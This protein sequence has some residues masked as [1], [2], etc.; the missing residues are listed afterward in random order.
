MPL[1][2]SSSASSRMSGSRA[3]VEFLVAQGV[4]HVFGNPGTT[5]SPFLATLAEYPQIQY[6]LALQETVA[7]TAADGYARSTGQPAFVNVHIT[8]GLANALCMLH[9]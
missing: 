3:L 6:I 7:I 2:P 5:E 4:R 1:T 9:E 8:A